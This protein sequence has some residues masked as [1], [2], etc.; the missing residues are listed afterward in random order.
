[1][2]W[3]LMTGRR[4]LEPTVTTALRRLERRLLEATADPSPHRSK[5]RGADQDASMVMAML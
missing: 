2:V 5:N 3:L 1:M 4:A